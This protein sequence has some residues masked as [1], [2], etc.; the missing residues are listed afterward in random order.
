VVRLKVIF[1]G[2]EIAKRTRRID[3]HRACFAQK[4]RMTSGDTRSPRL[5]E[6]R[7]SE[8]NPTGGAIFQLKLPIASV[9][10]IPSTEA[11]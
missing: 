2:L 11:A 7:M 4:A 5:S 8:V 1:N 6:I 9:V 10:E 3:D